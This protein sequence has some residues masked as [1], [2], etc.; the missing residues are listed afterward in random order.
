MTTPSILLPL[1][2]SL[3]SS[4][5]ACKAIIS[6]GDPIPRGD[7][8]YIDALS[9]LFVYVSPETPTLPASYHSASML[10]LLG[11]QLSA[12]QIDDSKQPGLK[13]DLPGPQLRSAGQI[14]C[15]RGKVS[16]S[17]ASCLPV[18]WN[19]P[20]E[21]SW[22]A[23]QEILFANPTMDHVLKY[24]ERLKLVDYKRL[25]GNTLS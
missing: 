1:N 24:L 21:G 5:A 14:L 18:F 6:E 8:T 16:T 12:M 9:R 15:L 2:R 13:H 10:S 11:S 19:T 7:D 17:S 3:A 23:L 20:K 4:N 25:R 22:G